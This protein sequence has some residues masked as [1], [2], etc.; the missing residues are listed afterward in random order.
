MSKLIQFS[1]KF[2]SHCIELWEGKCSSLKSLKAL[3]FHALFFLVF[4]LI[5]NQT[6]S[7]KIASIK[8]KFGKFPGK[9]AKAARVLGIRA[10]TRG[11]HTKSFHVWWDTGQQS[12]KTMAFFE[13]FWPRL[14]L[15]NYK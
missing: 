11:H 13:M 7:K 14:G 6:N 1:F 15:S 4:V 5:I 10:M 12:L 3:L 9:Q 8:A 2:V